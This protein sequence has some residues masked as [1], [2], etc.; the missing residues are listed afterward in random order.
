MK[1]NFKGVYKVSRIG[2]F[3]KKLEKGYKWAA[4]ISVDKKLIGLG[5]YEDERQAAIAYD[6]YVIKNNLDRELNI[7]KPKKE[8]KPL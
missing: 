1:S 3:G 5:F 2:G 8:T 7:L 6:K 4:K